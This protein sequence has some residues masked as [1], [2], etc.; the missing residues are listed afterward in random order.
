MPTYYVRTDGS[1]SNTG[2]GPASN[3]A[4]A[5]IG[6]AL[7]STGISSGD[8]VYIA[9]GRYYE[10]VTASLT[11]PTSETRIIGNP[12]ASQFAGVNAGIVRWTAFQ[13]D[14]SDDTNT[15]NLS[16]T[17]KDYLTFENLYIE[18]NARY[19][20]AAF[21]F[22]TCKYIKVRNCIFVQGGNNGGCLSLSAPA[23]VGS[24][25]I[26]DRNIFIG[27]GVTNITVTGTGSTNYDMDITIANNLSINLY[28]GYNFLMDGTYGGGV[29]IINNTV[30][31]STRPIKV[32]S[33]TNTTHKIKIYNNLVAFATAE[34]VHNGGTNGVIVGDY[35]RF[36]NNESGF[37][38]YTKGANDTIYGPT[39]LSFGA[40]R[41]FGIGADD[42]FAPLTSSVNIA[43]GEPN[44]TGVTITAGNPVIPVSGVGKT[45]YL[46]DRIQ[47]TESLGNISSSAIYVVSAAYGST[48]FTLDGLTPDTN[49]TITHR[50]YRY[51]SDIYNTGWAT[52][53]QPNA[54]SIEKFD[55]NTIG[56]YNPTEKSNNDFKLV[57]DQTQQSINVYLGATGISYNS[58]GLTAYYIRQNSSP[59]AIGLTSNTP[60][61]SWVSGGFSEISSSYTPGLYRLDLPDAVSYSGVDNVTVVLRGATGTNGVYANCQLMPTLTN[62]SIAQTVWTNTERTIT[63]GIADT[64]TT[65]TTRTGFAITS[66]QD[67]N[68][69]TI[70]AGIVTSVP[71]TET[72]YVGIAT[73]VWQFAN[74]TITGG[75]ADTVTT[76]T[77][78][79]GFAVSN[80]SQIQSGLSTLTI[81]DVSSA[82]GNSI[83]YTGIATS[84]WQYATRT[85]SSGSGISAYDVWNFAERTITGG[86]GVTINQTFPE[87]FEFMLITKSGRVYLSKPDIQRLTT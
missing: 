81:D 46:N 5:S 86:S 75:I 53:T 59:V 58:T 76:L 72:S 36:N 83:T 54:G 21:N 44:G 17:S 38:Q 27:K 82:I 14:T 70:T 40:E 55:L 42:F 13:S 15:P 32:N 43:F 68:G 6:K 84:V 39:G 69:Y 35:N 12:T 37:Y 65:L 18:S 48:S 29:Q 23:A 25:S 77:T 16:A 62:A 78:R 9:P 10:I 20:S 87:N 22:T 63:G 34:V 4:W 33:I 26:F 52:T 11:S 50:R 71:T 31:G 60:S 80:I 61:G 24:S 79:S 1:D 73:S 30:L 85:L 74:R 67:K 47:F 3:Q 19:T 28:S 2:L 45:Y 7:G 49:G 8:T 57:A 41:F 64:V 51:T 56:Y 66:N